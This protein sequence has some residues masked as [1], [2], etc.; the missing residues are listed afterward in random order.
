M[1]TERDMHQ[2]AEE[3][4]S[5]SRG[6]MAFNFSKRC[7]YDLLYK[8]L[9]NQQAFTSTDVGG[10]MSS[11][12][13]SVLFVTFEVLDLFH[14]DSKESLINIQKHFP[15]VKFTNN[16]WNEF[17]FMNDYDV[18]IAN[19]IFPNVDQRLDE[20]IEKFSSHTKEFRLSP[21]H[22]TKGDSTAKWW[23]PMNY[24]S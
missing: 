7:I 5:I 24:F 14:H 19:D 13:C 4:V 23:M 1:I 9:L 20:F 3:L 21:T 18:V 8:D 10:G 17:E 22:T 12:A 2:I 16:D 11:F 15:S 6:R